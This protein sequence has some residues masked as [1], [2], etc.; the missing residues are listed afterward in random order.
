[1]P[2]AARWQP[3][4]K[5]H[6]QPRSGN[7]HHL[8]R[9]LGWR[10]PG[11]QRIDHLPG[12]PRAKA[13]VDHVAGRRRAAPHRRARDD[14][15]RTRAQ[16]GGGHEAEGL[17]GAGFTEL[18]QSDPAQA[19]VEPPASAQAVPLRC[20]S[21]LHECRIETAIAAS[22]CRN[23]S[24]QLAALAMKS[25][26]CRDGAFVWLRRTYWTIPG[27]PAVSLIRRSSSSISP[28]ANPITVPTVC[29]RWRR[30]FP[31]VLRSILPRAARAAP[32]RHRGT[33]SGCQC[34]PSAGSSP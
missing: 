16:A 18:Q 6:P 3:D 30:R 32:G 14:R 26:S 27:R 20:D 10:P 4:E 31:A 24:S 1:M 23:A 9:E 22:R 17:S 11:D 12:R 2:R 8:A 29:A 28:A 7:R 19:L 25:A 13:A 5:R 33:C 34:R 21:Q 15:R